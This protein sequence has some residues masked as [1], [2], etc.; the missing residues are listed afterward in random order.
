MPWA[1]IDDTVGVAPC[2]A[3]SSPNGATLT[4]PNGANYVSLGQR[5]GTRHHCNFVSPKGAG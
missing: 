3:L 4:S 5:P 1:D 2:N